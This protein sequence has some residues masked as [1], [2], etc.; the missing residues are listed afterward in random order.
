MQLTVLG[1]GGCAAIPKP[2]CDCRVCTEARLKG[3]PYARCGPA[4]FVHDINL[5]IDTPA[6]ISSML[7]RGGITQLDYLLYTHLDPDHVEGSRIL[8]QITLDYRTW[9]AHTGSSINLL[10]PEKQEE[11]LYALK[12][13][14]GATFDYY[15]RQKFITIR[16]F[17]SHLKIDG[18]E[19]TA[20]PVDRIRQTVY[21]YVFQ[22]GGKKVV[23]APCDV[24]PFPHDR[25]EVRGADL[26]IIQPGFFEDEIKH[27]FTYPPDHIS[28]TTLY[29]FEQTL[30]LAQKAR[31]SQILFVH[32]EEH[33]NRSYDDYL[34][35]ASQ[36]PGIRFAYDG[37]Q[38]S[39]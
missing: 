4:V 12:S 5:L 11:R 21:I 32:L 17:N 20:V 28:R 37:M 14:Y 35:L 2:L 16:T 34:A 27:A 1:S 18:V 30:E 38:V 22:S 26:L 8:E 25:Q 23:Y 39:V 24:R 10:L 9:Q 36:Y 19:L 3:A 29:S 13:Q 31:A 33:W 7:N 6:E 15:Q